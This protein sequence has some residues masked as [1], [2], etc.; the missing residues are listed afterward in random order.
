MA[1]AGLGDVNAREARAMVDEFAGVAIYRDRFRIR[2]YGDN[3]NDWLTLDMRRVNN[4]S[5]RIGHNQVSG[6]LLI[7]NERESGLIERSSREGLEENESFR[8]LRRLILTLFD[9]RVEPKRRDFRDNAGIE[10]GTVD[11]MGKARESAKLRWISRILDV[12]PEEK[13]SEAQIEVDRES[14][15]LQ[16]YLDD[17][18]KEQAALN[19]QVTLGKIIGEVLHEGRPPVAYLY[20]VSRALAF[21]WDGLFEQSEE[22]RNH[23]E[24]FPKK[25]RLMAEQAGKL[26]R[27][28]QLLRPLAATKRT[29]PIYYNPNQVIIDTLGLFE[30]RIKENSV[31]IN[32]KSDVDVNDILGFKQDLFTAITNIIDNALYWL[33]HHD[34]KNPEISINV[35]KDAKE[36][37]ITIADNGKGIPEEFRERIF[38]VSFSLKPYGTGL[39]LAIARESVSRAGGKIY[40]EDVGVGGCFS[41]C[42]PYGG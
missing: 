2:P 35:R 29:N 8:R 33:N 5:L 7:S 21:W 1:R 36:C 31:N 28:F 25:L 41:I 11:S 6:I 24:E 13:K 42:L 40:L 10:R 16:R 39:G 26:R 4:P 14:R 3:D 19:A 17:L 15:K 12:V 18:E 27:L 34:I 20:D 23:R 38:D 9:Q 30:G 37:V 22:A 32:H